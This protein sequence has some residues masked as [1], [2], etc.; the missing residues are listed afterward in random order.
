MILKIRETKPFNASPKSKIPCLLAIGLSILAF[1]GQP[2]NSANT[3]QID[4]NKYELDSQINDM[5]WCGS[6]NEAILVLTNL[7]SIY[8]S[9]DRGTSWKKL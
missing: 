1:M 9:R 2:A 8:R 3:D 5:M 7:G 6:N 4:Y